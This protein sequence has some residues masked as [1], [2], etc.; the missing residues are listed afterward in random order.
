ML[1]ALQVYALQL[2]LDRPLSV[3]RF[4][5]VVDHTT[6]WKYRG[7]IPQGQ[8]DMALEIHLKTVDVFPDRITLIGEASLWK[9]GLRIYEV[10]DLAVSL[11]A[12]VPRCIESVQARE[13]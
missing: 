3:S 9:P 13:L 8:T 4:I 12:E 10:K 1:Q 2:N 5:N 11:G 6:V 7:Q